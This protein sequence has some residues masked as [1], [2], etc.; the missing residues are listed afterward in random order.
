MFAADQSVEKDKAPLHWGKRLIDNTATATSPFEM[1]KTWSEYLNEDALLRLLCRWRAKLSLNRHSV[2][3]LSARL[4]DGADSVQVLPDALVGLL[5]TRRHWMRMGQA[6][7][8]RQGEERALEM[9]IFRSALRDL[10]RPLREWPS[11]VWNFKGVLAEVERLRQSAHVHFQQPRL[12]LIPKGRE[13]ERR[14]LASFTHTPDRLLLSRA[15]CYLRDVFDELMCDCSFAFRKDGAYSY[16]SAIDE[17]VRYRRRF[18]GKRLYVAECDIQSFFDVISH[19][20]VE[21]AYDGFVQ[22]LEA[23]R[24]PD[25]ELRRILT[26]YLDVFTSRGNLAASDDPKVVPFR[27]LVKSLEKTGLADFY[28]GQK[29][30]DLPVGIPQGGALSPLIANLVLHSA[31]RAVR[32][33]DDSD[34]LYIR[35][36]DDIIIMHPSKAKCR[37]A[38]QRYMD[39]LELL[40]LPIHPLR[41]RV[42]YGSKYFEDKSK[43][44]FA[45]TEDDGSLK[46]AIP[47]VSFLGVN[48][49][50]DGA[51]CV[52]RPSVEKH[53]ERLKKELAR[54][55]RA[56]GRSGINLKDDSE[57][58]RLAILRAFEARLVAMGVGYSTMR[59]PEIGRRCWA[60]AFPAVTRDGPAGSQLRHLDSVRGHLVASMKKFLGFKPGPLPACAGGYYGRPYSYYGLLEAV[61]RHTSYPLDISAYG[62]W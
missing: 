60:A 45:W 28:P 10:A 9:T 8:R 50:Y 55:R 36:C 30:D 19:S 43:G 29:I 40:K 6:E 53:E 21:A 24:R 51:V 20:V 3:C 26:A 7:R 15:A 41:R 25:P 56:V 58:G 11:W 47:W 17:V 33:A 22:Q 59:R 13:K 32:S 39:A 16:K 37:E 35:F 2:Q 44:P 54:F 4:C 27:H 34:L 12:H 23:S 49:R 5:P 1:S 62:E 31:D 48:I 46:S 42:V 38:L 14:C 18:V 57:A 52:R 61:E